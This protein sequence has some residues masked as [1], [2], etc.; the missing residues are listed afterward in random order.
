MSCIRDVFKIFF[1]EGHQISSL[2]QAYFFS[3]R[4]NFKQL[5]YGNKNNSRGDRGHA[6][7]KIFQKLAYC[8][9]H[10]SAFCNLQFL[11]KG[12]SY[13]WP[14]PLSAS[15]NTMHFVGYAQ[16]WLCV[17]KTTKVYCNEEVRN[18]GKILFVQSIVGMWGGMHTPH[19]HPPPPPP[20][21]SAPDWDIAF[22][23]WW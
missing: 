6:P 9:S 18:Y 3:G 13:F 11:G 14:L 8:N 2:F 1:R 17:L 22:S 21:G 10:F 12:C 19:L 15:P 7:P 4:V 20:S 16:F 5:K 23:D